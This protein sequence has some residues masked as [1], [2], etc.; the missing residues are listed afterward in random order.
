MAWVRY[1]HNPFII[2]RMQDLNT[3][4]AGKSLTFGGAN[5]LNTAYFLC[6]QTINAPILIV[7]PSFNDAQALYDACCFF[8]GSTNNIIYFPDRETL[9]YDRFSPHE[10][11]TSE[12]LGLLQ[13]IQSKQANIVIIAIQT[14][15]QQVPPPSFV[16]GQ[17]FQ[18]KVGEH[19][20]PLSKRQQ[21]EQAGYRAVKQ[22]MRHGEFSLRGSIFDVFPMGAKQPFRIDLFDRDIDSIRTFDPKTQRSQNPVEHIQLL[23]AHEFPLTLEACDRFATQW[24]HYFPT[25]PNSPVLEAVRQQHAI[26]G[27]EYYLPL[28][29]P[30]PTSLLDY[31]PAES[32]VCR[33]FDLPQAGEKHWQS[34]L[35]RFR[36]VSYDRDYPPLLPELAFHQP[37]K[38]FQQ[39]NQHAQCFIE[40]E[41]VLKV[42]PAKNNLLVQALTRDCIA[43]I[44]H[45]YD[46]LQT[47]LDTYPDYRC[48]LVAESAGRETILQEQLLKRHY[49]PIAIANWHSLHQQAPGLY[50]TTATLQEALLDPERKEIILSESFWFGQTPLPTRRKKSLAE[51]G[52]ETI[53]IRDL[54][55]LTLGCL[56]V[57]LEHGIARYEGLTTLTLNDQQNEFLTLSYDNDDKLYVPISDCHL[58]SR[59]SATEYT[60]VPLNKLGTDKWSKAKEKA[61]KRIHDVAAELLSLYAHRAAQSGHSYVTDSED[62]QQFVAEFPF[63][64]TPDQSEAIAQVLQD[65]QSPQPMDRLLCG[66]VGFGKT[67]V[68]MRA[69]FTA[70]NGG[71]QVAILAPTTLLVQ[72]H[73]E[74]FSNRFAHWPIVIESLSRFKSTAQQNQVRELL[75]Q[76]KIDIIIGTHAL[77]SE[78]TVFQRLGLVI[79]D[80]EHRFG[81]KHKEQL[82]K[83]RH[84]VDMLS[85]TATPI[86]RTLN[87][88]LSSL[89]DLSIISTPP[90]K[91]LAIETFVRE[92]NDEIVKEAILR[93]VYRGGQVYFLHNNIDSIYRLQDELRTMLPEIK[94]EVAHGQMPER[95]LERI[96]ADFYHNRFQILICTTII[97]TGIDVPNANT[98]IIER[99]DKL[100]LAQLH[101]LRGRVGRSHHQAYAY[102]LTP[103]KELLNRDAKKRLEAISEAKTLGAGF[104]LAQNDLEIRGAGELLGDEQSG[105]IHAI[106]YDLYLET[107]NKAVKAIQSGEKFS[108]ETSVNSQH[109]QID[110]NISALIPDSYLPDI[111]TRLHFYQRIAKVTDETGLTEIK[112]ELIDRF[113]KLPEQAVALLQLAELRIRAEQLG[114]IKIQGN[115]AGIT[116]TSCT[117]PK[118]DPL[119][120]IKLVQLDPRQYQF[121]AEN[122]V[123]LKARLHLPQERLEACRIFFE[124]LA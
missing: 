61:L 36:T 56:V 49:H 106:G 17:S 73:F 65:M 4:K 2:H 78:K 119:R 93:E 62:Y 48:L 87:M 54:S 86:P 51:I 9:P 113:G 112:I 109:T 63:T 57:H 98:I 108:L 3:L 35:D 41:P 33:L 1:L 34:I 31:L 107:L 14:L 72:Q 12:R 101:Q 118:V 74:N 120:L 115:V 45:P 70:A 92:Y 52:E 6:Q 66:D 102:L 8:S 91:R 59:Y 46:H 7:T 15:C 60:Q 95:Q 96:M 104:I 71:K 68:A 20:D 64:E 82:K 103:P 76:G 50:T 114:F 89:R 26:G 94:T 116:F 88:A 58:I 39:C 23:P 11:L 122:A 43:G 110:L 111:P 18:L 84:N 16:H 121:S 100:G 21:L 37:S 30:E 38:L 25:Q 53:G 24:A 19:F 99:A 29:Y 83:L 42:G 79:V 80:E 22:V 32:M 117:P 97:E 40:K 123:R 85:M 5:L 13:K 67:E 105:N 28:F 10:D 69:A 47:L 90:A 75:A 124:K 77:L 27:L 44:S 55:E 81:V